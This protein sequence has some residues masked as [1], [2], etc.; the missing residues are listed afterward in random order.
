MTTTRIALGI[1]GV[2]YFAYVV[3]L[4]YKVETSQWKR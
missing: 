2:G 3:W 1:I 4:I